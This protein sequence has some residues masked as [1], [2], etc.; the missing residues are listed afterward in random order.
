M[1]SWRRCANTEA[2][3]ETVK[4]G[5]ARTGSLIRRVDSIARAAE[6][7]TAAWPFF[8]FPGASED[9]HARGGGK[10]VTFT[11]QVASGRIAA[12]R[13]GWN[14]AAWGRPHRELE[15]AQAPS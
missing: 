14:D 7:A 5:A 12:I 8:C 11:N 10:L 13:A 2:T 6:T 15:A 9:F 3:S 4:P 1:T